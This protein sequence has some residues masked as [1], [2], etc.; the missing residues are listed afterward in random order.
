[1]KEYRERNEEDTG[2]RMERIHGKDGK[3]T[4]SRLVRIPKEKGGKD[5]WRRMEW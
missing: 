5:T 2:R 3:N 1:M 4:G